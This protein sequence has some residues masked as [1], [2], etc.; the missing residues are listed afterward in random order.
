[1]GATSG[2]VSGAF[3]AGFLLEKKLSKR[4]WRRLALGS[5]FFDSTSFASS[6][7]STG[8]T[9]SVMTGAAMVS[10]TGSARNVSQC[11]TTLQRIGTYQ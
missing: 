9:A 7:V 4:D 2:L 5:S 6:L 3:S 1:M 8:G 11:S 10:A